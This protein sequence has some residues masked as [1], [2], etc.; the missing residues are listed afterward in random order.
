[1]GSG[2]ERKR[3]DEWSATRV[4]AAVAFWKHGFLIVCEKS[5]LKVTAGDEYGKKFHKP[6]RGRDKWS[7]APC[8]SLRV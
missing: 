4:T 8:R 7:C 3:G 2:K 5:K 6:I 1:M